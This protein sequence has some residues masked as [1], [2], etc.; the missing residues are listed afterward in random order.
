MSQTR[1]KILVVDDEENILEILALL[2]ERGGYEV[3]TAGS[4]AEALKLLETQRPNLIISD[5]NMPGMDGYAFF[6]AIQ[7][8]PLVSTT[9]FLFLTARG[10]KEDMLI[11]KELGADDYLVKP[12]TG[13]ELLASVRGKLRRV[14]AR[15]QEQRESVEG[16][17]REILNVLSHE[18]VTPLVSIKGTTDL[19]LSDDLKFDE[20]ELKSF[21]QSIRKGGDRLGHLVE[22]FIMSA[23]VQTGVLRQE[24]ELLGCPLVLN[25]VLE[26]AVERHR[27]QAAAKELPLQ[28]EPFTG[29][30]QVEAMEDHLAGIL[31]RLLDNAIKYSGR[32]AGAIRVQLTA[33]DGR[34]A[35][36]VEDHGAG[37]PPEQMESIFR[38]FHQVNRK[39]TE[40]QG[41]GLGLSLAQGMA[42][43]NRGALSGRSQLGQGSTF[44][45]TLPLKEAV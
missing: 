14:Q 19:L 40:Q 34:A 7:A 1:H 4:P 13:D 44:V 3:I 38:P 24:A 23:K 37:I 28:L 29:V 45:L 11:G 5:V 36:S 10:G 41:P 2:L 17:K 25:T 21:L 9:P 15:E 33:A 8:N 26:R 18:F 42:E 32:G 20:Q 31:D 30:V 35:V 12:L 22:D 6:Q 43:A 39:T 27:A 16:L